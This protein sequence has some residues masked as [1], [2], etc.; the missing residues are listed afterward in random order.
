MSDQETCGHPTGD[1][2]PCGASFGLCDRCERCWNHCEH[3]TD[4]ERQAARSKGGKATADRR[5]TFDGIDAP[6]E[7]E[8]V[9][10]AKR[11]LARIGRLVLQ[12]EISAKQ[13][14]AS[15]RA[16]ECW[17]DAEK[18]AEGWEHLREAEEIIKA[19]EKRG[20]LEAV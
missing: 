7:L 16:V 6:W 11:W 17:L 8:S 2:G 19:A 5:R 13:A 15:C 10:D 20:K 9:E 14:H 18:D 1:G 4:E 3:V 12:K